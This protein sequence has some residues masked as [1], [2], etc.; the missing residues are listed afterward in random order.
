MTTALRQRRAVA[1]A[2][3][4]D[5]PRRAQIDWQDLA[6]W[7]DWAALDETSRRRLALMAGVRVQAAAWRRCIDGGRLQCLRDLLGAGTLGVLLA[8]AEGTVPDTDAVP[9]APLPTT[10]RLE[11]DL[12]ALGGEVLLASVPSPALRVVLRERYWPR[13]LP[14]LPALDA[15]NARAVVAGLAELDVDGAPA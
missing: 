6:A 1:A 3:L 4:Q 8:S 7:P 5:D 2:A 15:Q 9:G 14:L 10:D 12:L 13:T 11:A